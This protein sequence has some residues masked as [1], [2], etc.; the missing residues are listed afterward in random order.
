MLWLAVGVVT[1]FSTPSGAA[2]MFGFVMLAG[3]AAAVA[4]T[5]AWMVLKR[6]ERAPHRHD[7]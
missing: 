3:I 4:A 2:W 6:A 7:T 1:L 5:V